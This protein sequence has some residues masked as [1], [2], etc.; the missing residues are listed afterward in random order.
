MH[1]LPKVELHVHLEGTFRPSTLLAL[2]RRHG[3]RLPADDAEGIAR[4]FRFRDFEHFVEVYLT[5]SS[6]LRDPEDFERLALDF[7]EGQARQNVL[8]SEVTFSISTHLAAGADGTAVAQALASAAAEGERRFGTAVRWIPDIVRNMPAD[9]AEATL[10]WALEHRARGVVALGAAGIETAGNAVCR[11][12]L[13]EAARHG[14]HR[15]VHAGE[16]CGPDAIREAIDELGAE[17]IGHGI[18]AVDDPPLVRRLAGMG[19]PLEICPSSNVCLG[20]VGSIETHPIETLRTNGVEISIGSDDPPFFGTTLE[21][22]YLTLAR[23]F[24]YTFEE[25]SGLARAGLRHAF[26]TPEERFGLET[27]FQRRLESAWRCVGDAA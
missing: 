25:L 17:R 12:P 7:V 27:D 19:I 13:L 8:W 18:R 21:G 4:W 5:C 3:V 2:A 1:A 23:A 11:G 6:C 22:E 20:L 16:Q 26:T 15:S 14:L 9:R 24:D 10:A